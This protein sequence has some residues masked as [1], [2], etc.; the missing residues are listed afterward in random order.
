MYGNAAYEASSFL[1]LVA[2][3]EKGLCSQMHLIVSLKSFPI[4]LCL[5]PSRKN[6]MHKTETTGWMDDKAGPL[7][8]VRVLN[9]DARTLRA[10]LSSALRNILQARANLTRPSNGQVRDRVHSFY[11]YVNNFALRQTKGTSLK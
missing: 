6:S 1:K 11:C 2:V 10:V 7:G 9:K 3:S 5:C 8:A 4:Q